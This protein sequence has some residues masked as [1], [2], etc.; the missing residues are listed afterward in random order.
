M[1]LEKLSQNENRYKNCLRIKI[2]IKIDSLVL[3][4]FT[5]LPPVTGDPNVW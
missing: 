5:L 4:L 2:A 3:S 1:I